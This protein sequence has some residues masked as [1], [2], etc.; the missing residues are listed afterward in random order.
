MDWKSAL[1][2]AALVLVA[3]AVV[4]IA[5]VYV[6]DPTTKTALIGA[7]GALLLFL[8]PPQLG[9]RKPQAPQGNEWPPPRGFS[10]VSALLGISAVVAILFAVALAMSGCLGGAG[11]LVC[12]VIHVADEICPMVLV[13]LPDGGQEA[14]PATEVQRL[15]VQRRAARLA[16]DGGVR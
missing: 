8:K 7:A 2:K 9:G 3:A 12:P 6:A 16:A 5:S 14:V 15:A 1:T 11:K 13:D 10:A 4:A